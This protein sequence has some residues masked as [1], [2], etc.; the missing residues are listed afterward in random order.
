MSNENVQRSVVLKQLADALAAYDSVVSPHERSIIDSA[1]LQRAG[2]H[3]QGKSAIIELTVRCYADGKINF[4]PRRDRTASL[5]NTSEMFGA[6][7][8]VASAA[9]ALAVLCQRAIK[10]AQTYQD[11]DEETQS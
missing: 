6:A 7:H 5:E 9:G 4:E 3:E 1:E 8:G 10:R 11:S 2:P